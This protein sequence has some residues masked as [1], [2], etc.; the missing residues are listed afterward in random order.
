MPADRVIELPGDC[1]STFDEAASLG[2]GTGRSSGG[3]D[4]GC[5]VELSHAALP[6]DHSASVGV[7]R[8][9]VRYVSVPTDYYD[10]DCW[11]KVEDGFTTYTK[12]FSKTVFY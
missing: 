5:H 11:W 4:H 10:A 6:L 9:R 3:D 8:D 7:E 1:T 2:S 12:E